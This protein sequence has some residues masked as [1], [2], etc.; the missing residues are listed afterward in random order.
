MRLKIILILGCC[1]S[2]VLFT[3]NKPSTKTQQDL[4]LITTDSVFEAGNDVTLKFSSSQ[5]VTTHLYCSNSYGS[6]LITP[7]FE[8]DNISFK[9]PSF[10]TKKSGLVHWKLKTTSNTFI[11]KFKIIPNKSPSKMETYLGPPSIE[12]GGSDYAMLVVIPTDRFDN[13]LKDSTEVI[14]KH[15]FL[16][17]EK[18]ETVLTNNLIAYKNMYSYA[19]SGRILASSEYKG[20]NSKEHDINVM[21]AIPTNFIIDASRPHEYADGNQITT[22]FTSIIKDRFNN[23][24]SDGTFVEFYISN[25]KNNILKTSGTTVNG[26]ASAKIVHPDHEDFWSVKA[27][28]NGMAESNS[29]S[30][31][32]KQ[33]I[34]NYNVLLSK[35]NRQITVGPLQ[36]FMSQLIPDGLQVSLLIYNQNNQLINTLNKTSYNGF[37]TFTLNPNEYPNAKYHL[38][39]QAAGIS[40]TFKSI[41]LW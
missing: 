10:I 36:S 3:T 33:V 24:V 38:D 41:N 40:K 27:I 15:Q 5:V 4:E 2:M 9:I 14:V 30:L 21:S 25:Q 7:T 23:I 22:F 6:T 13:A 8:E 20:V 19:N 17:I 16:N 29:I 34:S 18:S 37:V 31:K 28:I 32:Y 1:V 35:N 11:G 26:I 12:A 39:I